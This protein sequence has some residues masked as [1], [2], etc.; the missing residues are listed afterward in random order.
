MLISR[1]RK[2]QVCVLFFFRE[3]DGRMR[4]LFVEYEKDAP[5]QNR[6]MLYMLV[7]CDGTESTTKLNETELIPQ[8]MSK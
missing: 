2:S 3:T 5:M 7:A 6:E 8:K 4:F 1:F